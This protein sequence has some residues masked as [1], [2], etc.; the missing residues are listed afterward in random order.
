MAQDADFSLADGYGYMMDRSYLA[1]CRLNLQHYLWKDALGYSIHPSISLP[2]EPIIADI[3]TGT[4]MWLID[5]ARACPSAYLEGMDLDLSQ[6]PSSQWLPSN[7]RLRRWDIFT[8]VPDNMIG[9][10][11]FVHVRLL[12]LVLSREDAPEFL[13]KM[14]RMLKPGGYL[15]WDELDCANMSVKHALPSSPSPSIV[16]MPALEQLRSMCWAGGRHDWILDLDARAREV[17]FDEICLERCGDP[18]VLV[19]AFNEQHLLTMEEFAVQLLKVGKKD[20]ANVFYKVIADAY[21]ESLAGAA[22]CI[23]RVVCVGRKVT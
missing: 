14:L 23:P 22:L 2:P 1:A 6:A 8:D 4:A 17:G 9:K 21:R 10:Y 12:V 15:Q 3:A 20:E 7:A 11:D 13:R 18:D 19:R 5:V 16:I